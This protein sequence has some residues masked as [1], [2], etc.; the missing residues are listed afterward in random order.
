[1]IHTGQD[2]LKGGINLKKKENEHDY[3]LPFEVFSILFFY[4]P[5]TLI[6]TFTCLQ[7]LHSAKAL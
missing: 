2:F 5:S 1:M 3:I 7:R 6:T 4:C